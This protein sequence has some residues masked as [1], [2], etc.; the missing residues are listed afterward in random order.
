MVAIATRQIAWLVARRIWPNRGDP[1][2]L[3]KETRR[4]DSVASMLG[5]GMLSH[6]P[7]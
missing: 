4:L 3:A 1:A 6:Q 5:R 7:A 2:Q